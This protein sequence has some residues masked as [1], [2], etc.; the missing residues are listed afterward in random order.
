[1]LTRRKLIERGSAAFAGTLMPRLALARGRKAN[2]L[3]ILADDHAGYVLGADGNKWAHTPNLDR[4]AKEGTRFARNYCNAPVCTPSRQSFFTS[5]LP[6]ASGV[7]VLDTP[8]GEDRPTI[9]K[10]LA[11]SGYNPVVF[12][13]MHFNR[14]SKPGLHG[15]TVAE[16]EDVVL[17]QWPLAVGPTPRF[18]GIPTKPVWNPFEDPARIW[19][20]ADNLPFPRQYEQMESTWV[21]QQ[22]VQ[23]LHEHKNEPFALWVSFREPHSPFNFPVDDRN[24]FTPGSFAVPRLGPEDAS[25]IPL[26]FRGLTDPQKQGVTAAYY[27]SVQFLDR[28]IGVVLQALRDLNL[29]EDTLVVYMSDHGYS[30]GQHGRFEKHTCYEQSI[31]VPL[32]FRWP[33]RVSAGSVIE[34]LTESIDVPPTIMEMLGAIPFQ[35][36]HGRSLVDYLVT[37]QSKS[38]RRSIFSEY[39]ENEEACIRTDQWKLIYSSGK[40]RRLDGYRTD[41]LLHGRTVRL[42][43]MNDD[44]DEFHNVALQ[45]AEVVADL[46]EQMLSLFRNTHPEAGHEPS[47]VS[48]EDALDWYLRPRDA[49]M[50]CMGFDYCI[51]NHAP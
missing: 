35:V 24:D 15:F 25:E 6:H 20:N 30:L 19:L 8:L 13:K 23:Y 1:V 37:G 34:E 47:A 5:L 26:V 49:L 16:T 50:S 3:Y 27:T 18:N 21:A 29:D 31:R 33:G 17:T 14:Y 12:G 36:N 44:P 10:Q 48:V 46:S 45:H 39:L 2:L 38:P 9:A 43:N 22:A 32:I 4:L 40:R 51:S 7:T 42:Y 41:D 28:N 11:A